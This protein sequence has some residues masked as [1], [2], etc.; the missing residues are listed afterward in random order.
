MAK[1]PTPW[2]RELDRIGNARK[3]IERDAKKCER[4]AAQ[5]RVRTD[6]WLPHFDELPLAKLI[7]KRWER[8]RLYE[9]SE[10]AWPLRWKFM[11]A[12]ASRPDFMSALDSEVFPLWTQA[13][14]LS[15]AT[16]EFLEEACSGGTEPM[17]KLDQVLHRYHI[18]VTTSNNWVAWFCID[19]MYQIKPSQCDDRHYVSGFRRWR[20]DWATYNSG[21]TEAQALSELDAPSHKL[22]PW[23]PRR[24]TLEDFELRIAQHIAHRKELIARARLS[25]ARTGFGPRPGALGSVWRSNVDSVATALVLRVVERSPLPKWMLAQTS[26]LARFLGLSLPPPGRPP[27]RDRKY[28]QK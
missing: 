26:E 4:L 18:S 9:P 27:S 22:E 24:Q 6:I 17:T 5:L 13:K 15:D 21:N 11:E 8:T 19:R 23:D 25:P 7:P 12:L 10:N 3:A 1:K 20:D 2:E 28:P 16:P 14:A